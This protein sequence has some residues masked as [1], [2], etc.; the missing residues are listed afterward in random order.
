MRV[1]GLI[2]PSFNWRSLDIHVLDVDVGAIIAE[3]HEEGD[4]VIVIFKYQDGSQVISLRG[5]IKRSEE[6][7]MRG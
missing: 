3:S 1:A 5:L 2:M 6:A 7:V 4:C